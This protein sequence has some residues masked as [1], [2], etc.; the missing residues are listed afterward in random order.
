MKKLLLVAFALNL[1]SLMF[2]Q[3][4]ADL[5]NASEHK[6]YWLGI[7]YS[8]VK[9]IGSFTQFAEAG[10]TGPE[11]IKNKYFPAWNALIENEYEKYNVGAMLRKEDLVINTAGIDKI[12]AKTKLEDLEGDADPNYTAEQ[13]QKFVKSYDFGIKE[14][15]GV[16]FLA[17]SLNKNKERGKYHFVAVNLSNKEVLMSE[18]LI[19][20]AGGFGLR[21]YWAKSFFLVMDQIQ[22]KK[23]KE[24]K[25]TY[26]SK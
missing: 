10:E 1:S 15:I 9:L 3:T 17:E 18:P 12:N 7:D 21:N 20:E 4:T 22:S 23:Y 19:G 14:G 16:F 13:I 8:H 5:F 24:W 2:G 25:K 11:L 6:V 26:G